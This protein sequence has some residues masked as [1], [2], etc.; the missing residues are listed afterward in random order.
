MH[1][2]LGLIDLT[3][4]NEDDTP[5][6]I[7]ALC[8]VAAGPF[9]PPAA[10]CVYPE[11][12]LLARR[13]LDAQGLDA[14]R[15]AGVANFPDGGVDPDRVSRACRRLRA[16]GADEVDVVLPYRALQAGDV[17]AFCR[18]AE[19]AREAVGAGVLKCILET[20]LL[21]DDDIDR[22][23]ALALDAGADFL[24][25]ST[26][27]VQA[28]ASLPAAERLLVAVRDCGRPAGVK[29]S[30]GIRTVEQAVA[31]VELA[32]RVL[33]ENAVDARRFRIGA[34]ALFEAVLDAL[35]GARRAAGA[36][37]AY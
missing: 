31:Y 26:G 34:S 32:E 33:G 23:S 2:L 24:K 4:L 1:R 30:G 25:T 8:R 3:S 37:E 29:V 14:V 20:G 27:K 12:V 18:V 28:H 13:A 35:D 10:L 17:A 19:A 22:A 5:P 16:A 6:R 9:G 21:R 36:E 11:Y 7:E 15:V